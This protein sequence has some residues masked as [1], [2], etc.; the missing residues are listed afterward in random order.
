MKEQLRKAVKFY[1]GI[2]TLFLLLGCNLTTGASETDIPESIQITQIEAEVTRPPATQALPPSPTVAASSSET[3]PSGATESPV[4]VSETEQLG[5]LCSVL[6][7]LNLRSGPGTAYRPPLTALES[8][9]RLE[10]IGFNPVGVPGGSWVQVRVEGQQLVGWVSAGSQ[11]VSCN[12]DLNGLPEVAVAPPPPPPAP[13]LAESA[14]EGSFPETWQ[15]ELDF[16]SS[17][18]LRVKVFD[19][20]TGT[21]GDGDGIAE[22][23]FTVID[24]DGTVVYERTERTA[25]FC[26]FGG[27]EPN[28]NPWIIEDFVYKWQTGGPAAV[29]GDYQVNVVVQS[30]D[31]LYTGNW[32]IKVTM[33]FP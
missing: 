4:E 7:N 29:S 8:G 2:V 28:C 13:R 32:R 19:T 30:T 25:A 10:P 24:P 20:T 15:W 16:N 14:P 23:A 26:I 6:T 17:Y 12:L 22:V 31:G 5:P 9:T 1:F 33:E 27:G 11:F 21:T 3:A 18:L